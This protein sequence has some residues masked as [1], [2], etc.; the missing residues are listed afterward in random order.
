MQ[1]K[2]VLERGSEAIASAQAYVSGKEVLLASAY[3]YHGT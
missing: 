3:A 2:S 1:M